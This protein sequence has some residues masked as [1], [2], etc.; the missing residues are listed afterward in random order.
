MSHPDREN[1]VFPLG[2]KLIV[3][4]LSTSQQY[5]L[6]GHTNNISCLTCSQSGQYLASGQSTHMGF[7]ADVIIWSFYDRKLYCRL[8]LHKVRVQALAFSPG[9]KYLATVGGLDDNR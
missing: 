4:N 8:S 7:K 6:S 1:M 2:C 3:E 9:D 5:F